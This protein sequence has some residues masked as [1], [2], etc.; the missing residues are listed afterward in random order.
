MIVDERHG[1]RKAGA[2][3]EAARCACG[4]RVAFGDRDLLR[5]LD[6]FALAASQAEVTFGSVASSIFL[7]S[8]MAFF[9][10]LH[11]ENLSMSCALVGGE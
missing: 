4:H 8:L 10:G 7:H 6:G 1:V 3:I 5:S 2:T 11:L 9:D